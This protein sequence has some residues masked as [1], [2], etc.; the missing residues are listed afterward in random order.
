MIISHTLK[1]VK[2]KE[3]TQGTDLVEP[4][5]AVYSIRAGGFQD[6]PV[7]PHFVY[8]TQVDGQCLTLKNVTTYS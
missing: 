6:G 4:A 7:R 3:S 5:Y 2:E 1:E 8:L